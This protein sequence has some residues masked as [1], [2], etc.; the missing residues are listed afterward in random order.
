MSKRFP[1]TLQ[2]AACTTVRNIQVDM[3]KMCVIWL[4]ASANDYGPDC[5]G[6][7][8]SAASDLE[9]EL[10]RA[11]RSFGLPPT[12]NCSNPKSMPRPQARERMM[13]DEEAER[14]AVQRWYL[15]K[16]P[17][18]E[19]VEGGFCEGFRAGLANERAHQTRK[20]AI[21]AARIQA[22]SERN[23]KLERVAE[24]ERKGDEM[25]SAEA[26]VEWCEF[27][28][29]S[30]AAYALKRIKERDAAVRAAAI[31]EV[32]DVLCECSCVCSRCLNALLEK[33]R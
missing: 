25:E 14:E 19:T 11:L 3:I 10:K 7:V 9:K 29:P 20:D 33:S 30:D 24:P 1:A 15:A 32:R 6:S 21:A 18:P 13:N 22:L 5:G 28:S 8:F 31:R 12:P 23:E 17:L 2:L 16:T 4:M 27:Q 26:L